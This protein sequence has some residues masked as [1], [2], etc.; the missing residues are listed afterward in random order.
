MAINHHQA[1]PPTITTKHHHQ[2][3]LPAAT[4]NRHSMGCSDGPATRRRNLPS[5]QRSAPPMVLGPRCCAAAWHWRRGSSW[6]WWMFVDDGIIIRCYIEW[7]TWW[8]WLIMY[9]IWSC[10][11]GNINIKNNVYI[12]RI[13]LNHHWQPSLTLR[14]ILLINYH[15]YV[16]IVGQWF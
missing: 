4:T 1:S 5:L 11:H 7:V 16:I 3:S 14:F 13:I 2:P 6:W 10:N 8:Y 9:E 15:D 12:I